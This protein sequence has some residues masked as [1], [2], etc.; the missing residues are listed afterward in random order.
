VSLPWTLAAN[1][2]HAYTEMGNLSV[3]GSRDD[4]RPRLTDRALILRV[5]I[6]II[7]LGAILPTDGDSGDPST[8]GYVSRSEG[9][10]E[11]VDERT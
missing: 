9:S 11:G 3:L 4:R 10:G 5:P 1:M 7:H 8:Y 2:T 6:L